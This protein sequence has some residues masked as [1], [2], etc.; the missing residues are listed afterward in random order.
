MSTAAYYRRITGTRELRE[1][2]S[3]MRPRIINEPLSPTRVEP[4]GLEQGMIEYHIGEIPLDLDIWSD[5]N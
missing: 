4:H 3:S 1:I 5:R 2:P